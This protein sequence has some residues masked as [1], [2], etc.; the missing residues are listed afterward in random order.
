MNTFESKLKTLKESNKLELKKALMTFPNEALSTY[1]A[2]ANTD[3]GIIVLGIEETKDGLKISGVQ[4]PEKVKK[5]M[6]DSL[7]NAEKVNRNLINDSMVKEEIIDGKTIILIEVPRANFKEKPIYLKKNLHNSYKRNFE[8]DYK[9]SEEELK[10]MLRDQMDENFDTYPIENFSIDDFD[11]RT[12]KSYRNRFNTLNEDHPF[13]SMDTIEFLMKI[14]A[15][16][17]NRST[18]KIEPTLGGLLVFGKT[19][20]IKE[21]I[22]FIHFD[23]FDKSII[24]KERWNDRVVYDGT[25]G[26]GNLYNFF[27]TVIQK[28]YNLIEKNFKIADDNLS[29]VDHSDIH[30]AIREAFVNSIIHADFKIEEP[31]VVT[32]YPNYFQFENPGTLRVSKKQ[33]FAGE[34]SKP[35]N[36]AIQ[37]IFRHIK[38]C[39]RAGTGIP[40]ILKAVKENSLKYPDIEEKKD[41]VVFIFWD[42]SY[43]ESIENINETEKK[44]LNLLLTN[45]TLSNK[46]I[47]ESLNVT[48]YESITALNSLMEKA[49]I[50]KTGEGAGTK[51]IF[52]YSDDIKG[53]K[54]LENIND[55]FMSLKREILK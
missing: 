18:E 24:S 34:H 5:E 37:E 4:E 32:K 33:F 22:P 27:F 29:R 39:E 8:G 41:S 54:I 36:N 46:Q 21:A 51:Y 10:I 40:K 7:N 1:S 55:I 6:F 48:K 3:G 11:E 13:M 19:E 28:L 2:F 47:R 15:L 50:E 25:W 23:Y 17:K 52:K 35:R 53:Y 14:G 9:C 16:K 45:K 20:S 43:I 38:L 49:Y 26:E 12:I 31:L 44:I 42:T 30:I